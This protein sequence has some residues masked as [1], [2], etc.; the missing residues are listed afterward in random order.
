VSQLRRGRSVLAQA[1]ASARCT[2][3]VTPRQHPLRSTT[4]AALSGNCLFYCAS[5]GASVVT[6]LGAELAAGAAAWVSAICLSAVAA[7]P[8]AGVSGIGLSAVATGAAVE[9]SASALRPAVRFGAARFPLIALTRP[10]VAFF[11]GS[12]LPRRVAVLRRAGAVLRFVADPRLPA[13]L[14]RVVFAFAFDFRA[15]L[16][17]APPSLVG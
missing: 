2:S 15:V 12:D 16:A 4:T 10:R 17:M 13:F 6:G 8:A 5:A 3:V 11:T 9:V 14:V 1:K 7:S